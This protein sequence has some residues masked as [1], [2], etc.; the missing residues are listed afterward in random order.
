MVP[1][2]RCA[3]MN[4]I[5][6]SIA[7][8]LRTVCAVV[9]VKVIRSFN[10]W[11]WVR[12]SVAQQSAHWPIPLIVSIRRNY[13]CVLPMFDPTTATSYHH[14]STSALT[15]SFSCFFSFFNLSV[16]SFYKDASCVLITKRNNLTSTDANVKRHEKCFFISIFS[17]VL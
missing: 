14:H 15:N 8:Q 10:Q 7:V 4:E 9:F 11:Q 12:A 16:F 2:D 5:L 3:T 13:V 6:F 17:H 1:S